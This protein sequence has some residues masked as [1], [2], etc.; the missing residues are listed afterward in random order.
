[1]SV[2]PVAAVHS[3]QVVATHQPLN[4]SAPDRETSTEGEFSVHAARPVGASRGR[5][6]IDDHVQ[7]M[8]VRNVT[9]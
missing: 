7:E 3:S 6:D 1:M 2:A 5:V 8:S 9:G 4:A